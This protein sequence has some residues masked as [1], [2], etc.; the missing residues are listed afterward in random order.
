MTDLLD[1]MGW[2]QCLAVVLGLAVWLSCRTKALTW[3]PALCHGLWLLVLLKLV[4]PAVISVPL[5]PAEAVQQTEATTVPDVA[6][7]ASD[8][9]LRPWGT[10]EE[11]ATTT[12]QA[13]AAST[14]IAAVDSVE[15]PV[16]SSFRRAMR[17]VTWRTMLL[18]LLGINL[19]VTSVLWVAAIRQ[20]RQVHRLL[21]SGSVTS[22][23]EAELL[24]EVLGRFDLRSTAKLVIVDAP[25]TPMLWAAPG[26]SAIV[27]PR[28][29]TDTLDDDQLRSIIAHEIGHFARRDHWVNLFAFIVTTLFWWNPIAWLARRELA[30]AAEA[31]CDSIA[32]ERS[33]GSRKDYA[34]TLLAVVD[35]VTATRPLRPACGIPF[36]ETRSLKRR[37]EMLTASHV[38]STVSRAGWLL[39]AGGTLSLLLLPAHAEQ[40]TA[41]PAGSEERKTGEADKPTPAAT[42]SVPTA[43]QENQKCYVTGRVF[44]KESD[45]PVV[46][47]LIRILVDGEQDR[48]KRILKQTTDDAGRYRVEVP[49]GSVRLWFPELKPGYWLPETGNRASLATSPDTPVV[50]HDIPINIGPTWPIRCVEEGLSDEDRLKSIHIMEI[51][52]DATRQGLVSGETSSWTSQ[53]SADARLDAHG[54]GLLT[55]CGTTGKLIVRVGGVIAEFIV[56]PG[57]D[58]TNIKSVDPIAGKDKVVM[59]DGAGA[60]ATIDKAKVSIQNGLPLL[61]FQPLAGRSA[62]VATQVQEFS[63]RI[64]DAAGSPFEG[65][66]VGVVRGIE[67]GG[68]ADTSKSEITDRDG[69]FVVKLKMNA[70]G[71]PEGAF[72]ELVISKEGYASFDTRK[73]YF[74][75]QA[76]PAIDV[77]T[78]SLYPGQSLPIRLVDADGKPLAGAVVEPGNSYALRREEIRTDSQGRGVLKNLPSGVLRV[79]ARYGG[80]YKQA[81]L[82]VSPEAEKNVEITIRLD[83]EAPQRGKKM[84][85]FPPLAVGQP[86][87]EWALEGWS[88]G[89]DRKLA[90]YRGKIVLLDFWS[91]WCPGCLVEIPAMQQLD[92]KYGKQGVVFLAIHAI[93]GDL[94]RIKEL[95]QAKGWTAPSAV[96]QRAGTA[97][98]ETVRRYGVRGFSTIVLIGPD[99][100]IAYSDAAQGDDATCAEYQRVAKSLDI[101]WPPENWSNE[102]AA[103]YSNRIAIALYGAAI[104][105]T[106]A[107]AAALSATRPTVD[108]EPEAPAESVEPV[109]GQPDSE[110]KY[111]V[112]GLVYDK[113][114]RKPIADAR[115]HF[116]MGEPNQHHKPI[117]GQAGATSDAQ[118]RY[119]IEIPW[120]VA[121]MGTFRIGI[122]ILYTGYWLDEESVKML[123]TAAVDKPVVTHDI[124][125]NRGPTWPVHLVMRQRM[126]AGHHLVAHTWEIEDDATR[127][128]LVSGN[129]PDKWN[130]QSRSIGMLDANGEGL[131]T[132]CGQTGKLWITVG[133]VSAEFIVEPGF[134]MTKIKSI[135]PVVGTDKVVMVDEA[136]AKATIEK[137]E[138]S[139]QN[140]LPLL[141]FQPSTKR[142]AAFSKQVQRRGEIGKAFAA[143]GR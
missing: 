89:K 11:T 2:N 18:T 15:L 129:W 91:T 67:K 126:A 42:N 60:K 41:P 104:D 83:S 68:S 8:H 98:G 36:G 59:V 80:K 40:K 134:D 100:K 32:V 62:P 6:G 44:A 123:M 21:K 52:D 113:A 119:R 19:M 24:Q 64:V 29:L 94:S 4:T 111:Y 20:F 23:R 138:V 48:D 82:V 115:V 55:Q 95:Q 121:R 143:A 85:A 132:Q 96:D 79:D 61:T 142:T 124:A 140:G 65:V 131:L 92:E 117:S 141:M 87:P 33:A 50:T 9:F 110:P 34:E 51:E 63:G 73:I 97:E 38:S 53:S 70:N 74:P 12:A 127:Q 88:D 86:A 3:R 108:A 101:P 57:F 16:H 135:E 118:G 26:N 30:A 46:G 116:L 56:E 13:P 75:K 133:G 99:G 45:K 102:E 35:F 105:K 137:A 66:R 1:L 5:L 103:K 106:L 136:G 76:G 120:E 17:S 10:A 7:H 43:S 78:L 14:E 84:Q 49:M 39:L 25:I 122:S 128:A 139:L 47:V 93:N 72:I 112:T 22:G 58:M 69:R 114:T 90:D 130:V 109:P 125:A 81:E 31:C 71:E 107:A 54:A 28:G 27:L 77:G 37:F